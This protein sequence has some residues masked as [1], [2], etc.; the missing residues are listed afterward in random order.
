MAF[1]IKEVLE[2]EDHDVGYLAH[3]GIDSK[4]MSI[5]KLGFPINNF[6]YALTA[7][8]TIYISS[9]DVI[10]YSYR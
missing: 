3:L 5:Q 1:L 8:V 10:N 9:H 2:S 4:L 7:I 6:I